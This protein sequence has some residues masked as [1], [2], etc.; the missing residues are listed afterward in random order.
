MTDD[1]KKPA[2]R[3]Y[4]EPQPD[5]PPGC[6]CPLGGRGMHLAGSGC[7]EAARLGARGGFDAGPVAEPTSGPKPTAKILVTAAERFAIERCAGFGLELA[8]QIPGARIGN[9]AQALHGMML[10][11]IAFNTEIPLTLLEGEIL[12]LEIVAVPP[13]TARERYRRCVIVVADADAR[14]LKG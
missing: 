13:A 3:D 4:E 5:R 7:A 14:I 9:M 11:A 2:L 1:E 8:S 10:N 12:E 6:R